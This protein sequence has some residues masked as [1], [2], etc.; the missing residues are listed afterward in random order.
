[1]KTPLLVGLI[2]LFLGGLVT[3][4]FRFTGASWL[5]SAVP[6][7]ILGVY[8]FALGVSSWDLDDFNPFDWLNGD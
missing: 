4:G 6:G 8:T 1:M 2:A 3:V 5:A 7:V